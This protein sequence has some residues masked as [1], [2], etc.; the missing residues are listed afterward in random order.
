MWG[1]Q[2]PSWIQNLPADEQ[3]AEVEEWMQQFC[4]RYPDVEMIDVVNEPDHAPPSYSQ[5]LGGAGSTGYD[6]IIWS[7]EKA[8]RYCPDAVLILNDY[9]VLRWDTG[10]YIEI[11]NLLHAKG[12]LD[13]IGCQAHGLESQNVNELTSNL[14]KVAA[15]GV[16]IYI[17]EYEVNLANDAQQLAVFKEQFP[18]FFN[19][20]NVAG[21]TLWGYKQGQ[22]WKPEAFLL[23]SDNTPR[24]ALTWLMDYLK[25]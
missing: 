3:A 8:R 10:N 22:I 6:W 7:F 21:I 1:N 11:A 15:I 4:A 19:H 9:N 14:N 2:Q 12:L 13:A 5:A 20:P 18:L 23:N 25:R 16:P 17:S 24:P